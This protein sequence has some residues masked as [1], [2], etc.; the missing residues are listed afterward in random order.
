[1]NAL[2][3]ACARPFKM[4]KSKILRTSFRMPLEPRAFPLNR[5]FKTL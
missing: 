4:L 5:W 1:M 3:I 2:L